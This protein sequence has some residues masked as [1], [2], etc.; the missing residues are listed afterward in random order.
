MLQMGVEWKEGNGR[1]GWGE[2][3][4]DDQKADILGGDQGY[5]KPLHMINYS[6][7][8]ASKKM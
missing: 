7:S 1:L 4:A 2:Q 5:T 6:T 8:S 3:E